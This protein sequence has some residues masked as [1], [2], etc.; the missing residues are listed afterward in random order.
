[1]SHK[2]YKSITASISIMIQ[3]M[4]QTQLVY[5]SSLEHIYPISHR[6]CEFEEFPLLRKITKSHG[7]CSFS[8]D[9]D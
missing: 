6:K 4:L 9:N 7:K 3:N 1:M 2:A 8:M 5:T